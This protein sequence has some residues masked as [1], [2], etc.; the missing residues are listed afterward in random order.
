ML[1]ILKAD[2]V[3]V[4]GKRRQV[5]ELPCFRAV[6]GDIARIPP[7]HLLA[8]ITSVIPN[9]AIAELFLIGDSLWYSCRAATEAGLLAK[10]TTI[11]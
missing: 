9:T 11:E 3:P 6:A 5:P 1:G 8:K 7:R 4:A 10:K 2:S